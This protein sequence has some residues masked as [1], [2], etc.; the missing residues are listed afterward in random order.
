MSI[1]FDFTVSDIDAENIIDIINK[2][3]NDCLEEAMWAEYQ[4]ELKLAEAFRNH[5]VYIDE[6]KS[7]MLN[8]KVAEQKDI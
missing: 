1:H 2:E 7:K 5:A 6:L 8:T 4:K 3:K